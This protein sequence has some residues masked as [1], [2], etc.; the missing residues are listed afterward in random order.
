[1]LGKTKKSPTVPQPFQGT[2]TL[3]RGPLRASAEA[4]AAL[5][6]QK[7]EAREVA[8]LQREERR[9]QAREMEGH[10]AQV[11]M[12][13]RAR[14]EDVRRGAAG[15]L[16]VARD[17][18]IWALRKGTMDPVHYDAGLRFRA[19]YEKANG[20]GVGSC[21]AD[22]GG[23]SAFNPH[24]SGVSQA[25]LVARDNVKA[26]LADLGTPLLNGYVELVAGE[27]AMLTDPRI[28][29]A[30]HA[31]DHKLPCRIA[32]DMLARHYGMIR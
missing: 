5:Q 19:D 11:T 23:R 20:T 12:D 29:G 14:G 3:K 30:K 7:D 24:T 13:A 22:P 9:G 18:L 26:A 28:G 25:M 4:V 17:G 8:D 16:Q 10:L 31:D 21:L 1:M 32:F 2:G 27:G 15:P 6:R